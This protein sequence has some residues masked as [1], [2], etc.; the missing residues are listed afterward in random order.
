MRLTRKNTGMFVVAIVCGLFAARAYPQ[1]IQ[2]NK[3]NRTL[4]ITASDSASAMA[5]TAT[6]H[7]GFAVYAP[8]AQAAYAK[9]SQTSNAIADALAKKGVAKSEIESESQN[10]SETPQFELEKLPPAEQAKKR[11]QLRQSWTVKTTA[12]DAAGVLNT[13]VNAGANQSGQIDWSVADENG[14]EAKAAGKALARARAIAAQMAQGLGIKLGDLIYAS[15][16][17]LEPPRPI[18][19]RAFNGMVAKGESAPTP[20][21]I[22]ARKVERSATV[23]AVFSIE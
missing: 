13:A 12:D 5:D 11:F 8:D 18:M 14:L 22:N 7:I 3:D 19:M 21:A 2:V 20:L 4:A 6:V 10:I 15:N 1:Q 17:N 9:G 23:Y 16:Q